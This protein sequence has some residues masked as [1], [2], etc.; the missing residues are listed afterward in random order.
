MSEINFECSKCG[1]TIDAPEEMCA[2]LIDCPACKETIEVPVRGRNYMPP[3][4]ETLPL[5]DANAAMPASESTEFK[6]PPL[7]DSV[8]AN[9]LTFVAAIE[10]IAAPIV[11]VSI[12]SDRGNVEAGWFVVV[13]GLISGLILLGFARV[14]EN[15]SRSAQRLHRIE[16]LMKR[17]HDDKETACQD[18]AG[19]P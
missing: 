1:Q 9:V 5:P 11:G 7:E 17:N 15:T 6:L 13:G 12:G 14:I 10:L 18:P 4:K 8:V 16:L 3:D 2:Q 19:L